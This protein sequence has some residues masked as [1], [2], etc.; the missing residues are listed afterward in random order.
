MFRSGFLLHP[1]RTVTLVMHICIYLCIALIHFTTTASSLPTCFALQA[2][3]H[4]QY[5]MPESRKAE[6]PGLH[7][8]LAAIYKAAD[9]AAADSITAVQAEGLVKLLCGMLHPA[10]GKRLKP[11]RVSKAEYPWLFATFS[12]KM[13]VCPVHI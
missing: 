8:I 3:K 13:P 12:D 10:E 7:P 1:I 5:G 11:C 4:P 9:F 6:T 2:E